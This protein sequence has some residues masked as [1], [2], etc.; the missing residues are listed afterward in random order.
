MKKLDN[1]GFSLVELMVV[2][3][4]IAVIIGAFSYGYSVISNKEVDQCAKKIQTVLD[5]T[6]NTAMG[7]RSVNLQLYYN[8]GKIMAERTVNGTEVKKM[9]VGDGSLVVK[10]TF[11]DNSE[12]TL[13]T[14]PLSDI[15]FNRGSGALNPCSGGKYLKKITISNGKKSVYVE[16]E[17][18]TGRVTFTK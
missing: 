17:K 14:D 13:S 12:K 4:I 16:I 11:T 6:R 10:Y 8:G 3:G 1:R 7:K 18:L 9:E 2:I 15:S 5:S